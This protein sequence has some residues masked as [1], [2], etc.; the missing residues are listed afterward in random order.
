MDIQMSLN[1]IADTLK[2][3]INYEDGKVSGE[4]DLLY[5]PLP[6]LDLPVTVTVKKMFANEAVG[7]V[8]HVM[9]DLHLVVSHFA[10]TGAVNVFLIDGNKLSMEGVKAP[11]EMFIS[12]TMDVKQVVSALRQAIVTAFL[13]KDRKWSVLKLPA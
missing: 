1:K 12:K 8:A 7:V 2:V 10:K 11:P 13:W 9:G 3:T 6:G 4:T 5:S